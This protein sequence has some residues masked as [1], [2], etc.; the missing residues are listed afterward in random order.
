MYGSPR[1]M[2]G[3][4]D[5]SHQNLGCF[6]YRPRGGVPSKGGPGVGPQADVDI[7]YDRNLRARRPK[8]GVAGSLY[9]ASRQGGC[10]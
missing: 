3:N 5:F 9:S 4:S 1:L 7:G 2:R 8:D 6:P 10:R